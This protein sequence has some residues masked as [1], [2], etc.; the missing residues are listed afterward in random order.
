MNE[1]LGTRREPAGEWEDE[2]DLF[3]LVQALLCYKWWIVGCTVVALLLGVAYLL[4]TTPVYEVKSQIE[5]VTAASLLAVAVPGVAYTL[6]PAGALH[7]VE[8]KLAS[9]TVRK[10]FY[11]SQ[12]KL[13][14]PVINPNITLAQSFQKFDKNNFDL[15]LPETE[16]TNLSAADRST[17]IRLRYPEGM[18]GVAVANGLVAYAIAQAKAEVIQ[19]FKYIVAHQL[20]N[21]RYQ[22]V[23]KRTAY[24]GGLVHRKT[25]LHQALDVAEKLDI[26]L[27]T[28]PFDLGNKKPNAA[29]GVVRAE[30]NDGKKPLYFRGSKALQAELNSLPEPF[31]G[32]AGKSAAA[33]PF[34]DQPIDAHISGLYDLKEKGRYLESLAPDF[35]NLRLVDI[36]RKA[37]P[38]TA[39]IK[40]NSKLILALA[41][42]L[43]LMMGCFVALLRAAWV[44][45]S[46]RY[47]DND[48]DY[49]LAEAIA[50][51]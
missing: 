45:R 18:N 29:G 49:L 39:A 14:K 46:V 9:W 25:G 3:E 42:V 35:G 4:V 30:V 5:P 7:K 11:Q 17:Y 48:A 2:I 38:P 15:H 32:G 23:N 44:K 21:L 12:Q 16:G 37:A 43:G 8:R 47:G 13:L 40:P 31:G 36:T 24:V 41:L 20:N 10:A 26:E 1:S 50:Q 22:V 27:P 28:R 33:K 6:K 51:D 19:N 34:A